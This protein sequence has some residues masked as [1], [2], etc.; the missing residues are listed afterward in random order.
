MTIV[1]HRFMNSS[2]GWGVDQGKAVY[3]QL[4]M[5]IG[6]INGASVIELDLK[7]IDQADVSFFREAIVE[8]LRR[9]RPGRQFFLTN[10]ENEAIVE[11]LDAAFAR[12]D[13][14]GLLRFHD[15]SYKL[16]GKAIGSEMESMLREV[17]TLGETTSRQLIQRHKKLKI[18]SCSNRL[19]GLWELGLLI[20]EESSAPTGGKEYIYRPVR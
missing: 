11:N 14:T 17:E 15:G 18:Q 2:E 10:I 12:R 13:E 9:Y 16:I 4:D 20:R 1:V 8:I 6:K 3:Q 7:E 5:E 19:K